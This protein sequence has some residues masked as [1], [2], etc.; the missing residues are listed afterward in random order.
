MTN[1]YGFFLKKKT[2]QQLIH[3]TKRLKDSNITF[4]HKTGV[5][6]LCNTLPDY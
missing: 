4:L 2:F 1:C 5:Q 6:T 3:E